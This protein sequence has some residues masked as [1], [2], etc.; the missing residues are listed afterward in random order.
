MK[1]ELEKQKQFANEELDGEYQQNNGRYK[2]DEKN[3][4]HLLD[5][6]PL[7]GTSS[8]SSVLAKPLTWW[9]SGLA[10]KELGVPDPKVFTKMKK[11]QASK[12]E[13]EA[14]NSSCT[15]TLSKIRSMTVDDY[16]NLLD[17]AYRAHS[18]S[19]DKSAEEGTDLHAELERYVKNHM[20][21]YG[22]AKDTTEYDP[23]IKPFI[24]WTET[25]VERFIWSEAHCYSENL[26]IGGISDC[27]AIL[28]NGK[29]IIIDFKS[30]KEA[31]LS[32]FWQCVG[33]AIQIEENGWFNS[34]GILQG[35]L[36]APIDY[37]C[38]VP[39]GATNVEPQFYYNMEEGKEAFHAEIKLYKLL[40]Q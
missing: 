1:N 23:K 25:N 2:F 16:V 32:Q 4:I 21:C 20:L 27:G 15:E 8:A 6:R 34:E 17:R 33:Y 36:E 29:T 24:D 35:K 11:K 7:I 37:V 26:W 13:L 39:F 38:I 3:H 19:L 28:K 12:D 22:K 5:G 18:L 40:N 31:Y 9:A 14:L 10:V 30:S